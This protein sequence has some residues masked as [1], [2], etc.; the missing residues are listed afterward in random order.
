MDGLQDGLEDK[1]GVPSL[2]SLME[3]I[4]AADVMRS[5]PKPAMQ[6]LGPSSSLVS[7]LRRRPLMMIVDTH[8][9]ALPHW[10]EPVETLLHQMHANGVDKATLV[11]VRGQFDNRSPLPTSNRWSRNVPACPLS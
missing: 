2:R 6:M 10:F 7:T 11:Q 9:H 8:C 5:P 3:E 1:Y 4:A